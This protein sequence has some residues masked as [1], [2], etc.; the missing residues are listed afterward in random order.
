MTNCQRKGCDKQAKFGVKLCVPAMGWS[1]D[2]HNPLA[3]LV[4][5]EV[6]KEHFD[7]IIPKEWIKDD[8]MKE[9]FRIAARARGS[10]AVPPDFERVF[11]RSVPID[12]KEWLDFLK[13]RAESSGTDKSG[14]I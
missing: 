9:L 2:Q 7:E 6:C 5:F 14:S 12:S 10:D 3:V 8:R 13:M 1:I 11:K 4:G